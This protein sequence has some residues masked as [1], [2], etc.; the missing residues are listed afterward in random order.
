MI[1]K[2]QKSEIIDNIKK[3][4]KK[5]SIVMFANFHGLNVKLV[6]EVRKIF[7]QSGGKNFVTRK[8]FCKKD[9]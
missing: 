4:V 5:S 2:Q 1:T 3:D 7:R 6:S 9:F 8:K